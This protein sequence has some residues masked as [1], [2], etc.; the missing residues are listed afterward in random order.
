MLNVTPLLSC[1]LLQLP[2]TVPFV[3]LV[4]PGMN[5]PS[6]E[7]FVQCRE[8]TQHFRFNHSSGTGIMRMFIDRPSGGE[9]GGRISIDNI[10]IQGIYLS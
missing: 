2:A 1:A 4:D 5:V 9:H 8:L 6:W 7:H 10:K 3:T